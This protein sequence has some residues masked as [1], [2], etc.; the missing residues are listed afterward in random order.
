METK[1]LERFKGKAICVHPT[2]LIYSTS[3]C[4]RLQSLI[5]FVSPLLSFLV[6]LKLSVLFALVTCIL[7]GAIVCSWCFVSKYTFTSSVIF[8]EISFL[9][10][11]FSNQTLPLD[12][13]SKAICVK[14]K[15][16]YS[17]TYEVEITHEKGSLTVPD[18]KDMETAQTICDFVNKAITTDIRAPQET[19]P[20]SQ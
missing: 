4:T 2:V 9:D 13:G 1:Y 8:K 6:L 10:I 19:L 17:E 12:S 14:N 16:Q 5:L 7:M 11:S 3:R 20:I 15:T 18:L